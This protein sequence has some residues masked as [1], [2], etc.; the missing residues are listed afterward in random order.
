MYITGNNAGR[1]QFRLAIEELRKGKFKKAPN[2][3]VASGVQLVAASGCKMIRLQK[4]GPLK[5]LQQ[6]GS[7]G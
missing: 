7:R 1:L 3:L 2:G 6:Q 5:G 4:D